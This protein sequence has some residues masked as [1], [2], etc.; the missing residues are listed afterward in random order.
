M[1]S[2]NI[3]G[4]RFL[5]GG[6]FQAEDGSHIWIHTAAP[7]GTVGH[8]LNA[9][10]VG[11]SFRMASWGA[12]DG[13]FDPKEPWQFGPVY[14]AVRVDSVAPATARVN[15]AANDMIDAAK[16][17]AIAAYGHG[18]LVQDCAG[19]F[20]ALRLREADATLPMMVW[21][22]RESAVRHPR[23]SGRSTSDTAR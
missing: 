8:Q 13:H 9:N 18:I 17:H 6:F 12:Y 1:R 15:V 16:L 23:S 20:S 3:T 7:A 19:S 5:S 22:P 2:I 21:G 10:I 4:N 11:N 14:A